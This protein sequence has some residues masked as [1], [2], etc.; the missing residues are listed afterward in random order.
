MNPECFTLEAMAAKA[1]EAAAEG[2]VLLRNE[3][4]ALPLEKGCRVAVFGRTQ[5]NYYKSGLGSGGL[6]NARYVHGLW[7]GLT[8]CGT[9]QLCQSRMSRYTRGILVQTTGGLE[10][11][12]DLEGIAAAESRH[13]KAFADLTRQTRLLHPDCLP[14]TAGGCTLCR[15]CTYPDKPCRFPTKRLSSM[16]AY[17]LLVSDVCIKSGLPYN[18][19]PKTITYTSC[20]LFD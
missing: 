6:V 4:R 3:N 17:G 13:K 19:G 9:L 18:H 10:D 11:D 7:E 1:R 5:M 2:C 14:L 20:I 15:R 16:E 12:F 8:A